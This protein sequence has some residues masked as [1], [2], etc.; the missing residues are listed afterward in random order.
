M[1][2]NLMSRL[3]R[4]SAV[5]AIAG[6][7]VAAV[8]TSAEAREWNHGWHGEGWNHGWHRPYYN[9]WAGSYWGPRYWAPPPVVYAPPVYYGYGYGA[10]GINLNIP[11]P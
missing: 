9:H 5:I 6:L 1:R 11:L 3:G 7:A 8:G 2:T 4:A 10:P